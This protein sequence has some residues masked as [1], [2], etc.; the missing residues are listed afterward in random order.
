MKIYKLMIFALC[1]FAFA[2]CDSVATKSPTQTLQDFVEASK[3]KDTEAMKKMLSKGSLELLDKTAKMQKIT[4]DE[5]LKKD[6]ESSLRQTPETRNEKIEGD[7][8]T[9]E[10]K[11]TVTGE[12]E[13]IPFVKE[14]GVW[15]IALDTL[16]NDMLEKMTQEMQKRQTSL[17]KSATSPSGDSTNPAN[18]QQ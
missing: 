4:V 17:P 9:V 5:V 13:K 6:D 15:K 7:K 14:E 8:A 10:T 16:M 12:Y 3:K 1:A 2:A 18:K 11:N